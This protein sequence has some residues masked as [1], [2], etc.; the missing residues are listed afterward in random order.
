MKILQK[1]SWPGNIRELENIIERAIIINKGETLK[2]EQFYKS[3]LINKNSILSLAETEKQHII[4]ALNT[5]YWQVSGESGAA[6]ILD[7]HPET[8]RSKMRKLGIKRPK[9]NTL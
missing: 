2:I 8:L 4:K 6:Q 7:I 1:Y 9:L 3:E 5:T